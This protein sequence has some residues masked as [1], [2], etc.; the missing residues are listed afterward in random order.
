MLYQLS[1]VFGFRFT[2]AC[3]Q[4]SRSVKCKFCIDCWYACCFGL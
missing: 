2:T 3:L 4:M 1:V